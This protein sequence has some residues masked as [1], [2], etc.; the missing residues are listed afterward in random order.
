M[1]RLG[2]ALQ[3]R[4]LLSLAERRGTVRSLAISDTL[5]GMAKSAMAGASDRSK[6][7][8]W[9]TLLTSMTSGNKWSLREW[10]RIIDSQMSSW[11]MYIPGVGSSNEVK[12]LKSFK[13]M[14]DCF[15]EA[16]LDDVNKVTAIA[17]QRIAQNSSRSV[18]DVNRLIFAY[19]QSDILATWLSLKKSQ[20]EVLPKS[21]EELL[22]LQSKDQRIKAIAKKMYAT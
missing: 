21:E 17:R 11:T 1:L 14:L 2:S 9:E 4:P 5:F 7:K 22:D 6:E 18:D 10:K 8:Q 20:G 16:E 15:S 19:K 3:L 13:T 12:D